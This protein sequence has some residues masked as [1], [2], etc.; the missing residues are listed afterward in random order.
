MIFEKTSTIGLLKA[1]GANNRSVRRIFLYKSATIIAKGIVV[2]DL[3]AWLL[4]WLQA[5]FH[6]VHLDSASY[7]MENVP[8][9]LNPWTYVIISVGSL[10]VCMVALLVPT[11]YI[12]HI[13]PAKTIKFD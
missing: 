13:D 8:I 4:C 9:D 1:L 3:V 12:S 2:G 7:M 5:R 6:L 10:V 11:A